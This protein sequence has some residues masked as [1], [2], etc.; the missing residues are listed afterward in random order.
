MTDKQQG[1]NDAL[2]IVIDRFNYV[3]WQ[4]GLGPE[5]KE[6]AGN[7]KKRVE[8][9]RLWKSEDYQQTMCD[10]V[11]PF[12][13]MLKRC[14]SQPEP[15]FNIKLPEAERQGRN[16]A[17]EIVLDT[18]KGFA[19]R[20]DLQLEWTCSEIATDMEK[21]V[22][23]EVREKSQACWQVMGDGVKSQAYQQAMLDVVTPFCKML[24]G[25]PHRQSRP[26]TPN[27]DG[28]PPGH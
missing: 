18:F 26:S 14:K 7:M 6:A 2:N 11:M 15:P 22:E 23:Y 16:D 5:R 10:V 27:A 19:Q 4:K 28:I 8:H 24:K 21:R 25:E 20:K 1:W 12:Y 13:E 17:L 3:V 9:E